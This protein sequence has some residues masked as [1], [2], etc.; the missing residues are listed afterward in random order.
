LIKADA[1]YSEAEIR[2]AEEYLSSS[3]ITRLNNQET[4]KIIMIQQR[5][6]EL[7]P[8]GYL[9]EKGGYHVLTLPAIAQQHETI[10]LSNG[11]SFI[12]KPGD[13]LWPERFSL[14]T[15]K[16]LEKDM[17]KARFSAQYLQNPTPPGGNRLSREWF[18]TYNFEPAHNSFQY[19]VQSWDTGQSED[20]KSD[21]SVC[22]TWGLCNGI[23]HLLDV[24]RDRLAYHQLLKKAKALQKKWKADKIIIEKAGSGHSLLSD[25]RSREG[26]LRAKA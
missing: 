22:T 26:G 5:L 25:L 12:R 24:F 21:F 16:R 7:D 20:P 9:K 4:G 3:L 15:L 8:A 14:E 13:L 11:K 23:W 1:A 2:R 18:K 17:G 6:S 10:P 19:V